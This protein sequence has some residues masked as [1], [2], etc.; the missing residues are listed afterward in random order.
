MLVVD[1][2]QDW[3]GH[4]EAIHPTLL[5]IFTEYDNAE[6]RI[7]VATANISKVGSVVQASFP[8][9]THVILEKN[10]CMPIFAL[11]RFKTCI[12]VIVGVDGPLL[13]QQIALNVPEKATKEEA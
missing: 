13:L 11:Y 8:S 6:G 12:S 4:C 10:G 7:T 5:R 2:H 3:C 1:V 9:D